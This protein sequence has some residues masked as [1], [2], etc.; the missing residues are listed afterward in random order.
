[1]CFDEN[2]DTTPMAQPGACVNDGEIAWW[3]GGLVLE[4][5]EW[6]R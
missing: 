4:E 3:S 1:V 2:D 5:L 6:N